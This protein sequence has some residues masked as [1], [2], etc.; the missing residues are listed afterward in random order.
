MGGKRWRVLVEVA[1]ARR[2]LF[3][4]RRGVRAWA[5]GG[6]R[7]QGFPVTRDDWLVEKRVIVV[8]QAARWHRVVSHDVVRRPSSR[9][10]ASTAAA[11]A[12]VEAVLGLPRRLS[13]LVRHLTCVHALSPPPRLDTV[14]D[15]CVTN[16]KQLKGSFL[17]FPPFFAFYEPL[18]Y[19]RDRSWQYVARLLFFSRSKG[20]CARVF[21]SGPRASCIWRLAR[22]VLPSC[23]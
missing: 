4:D 19:F 17:F 21:Q 1:P 22:H 11:V 18:S 7:R 10:S 15:R 16:A 14:R 5:E 8:V 3:P 20:F 12:R 2:G 23:I 6:F 13:Y 9:V